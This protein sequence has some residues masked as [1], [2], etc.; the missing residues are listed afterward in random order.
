MKIFAS[1]MSTSIALFILSGLC[2]IFGAQR[3]G[4]AFAA[5]AFA[6]FVY[7]VTI[8]LTLMLALIDN[9]K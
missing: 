3:M 7:G 6:A 9:D 5:F 8:G 1:V 4:L 2:F